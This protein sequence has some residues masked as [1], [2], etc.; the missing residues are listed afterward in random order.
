MHFPAVIH[1]KVGIRVARSQEHIVELTVG[2]KWFSLLLFLLLAPAMGLCATGFTFVLIQYVLKLPATLGPESVMII[3]VGLLLGLLSIGSITCTLL[4]VVGAY[5]SFFGRRFT[6]D[7]AVKT[8]RFR[9]IP[10]FGLTFSL[11]EI[12]SVTLCSGQSEGWSLAWL[13]FSMRGWKKL[14]RIQGI[15]RASKTPGDAV[16][17]LEW[18]AE[19][20]AEL[21]DKPINDRENVTAFQT[22]WQ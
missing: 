7:M 3:I 19:V 1:N 5:I 17:E 10:G 18:A 14:F 15:T 21:L 16:K 2:R 20:L 22:S 13:C 11:D 4:C 9:N 8:C 6:F 12:E